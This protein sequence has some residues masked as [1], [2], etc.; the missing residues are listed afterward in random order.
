MI[1]NIFILLGIFIWVNPLSAQQEIMYTQF[2]FNKMT[3]NPAYA[4]L[5]GYHQF[6]L[7]YRDQ[8]N[9]FVG[10]PK[11]QNLSANLNTFFDG[12]VGVGIN[13]NRQS[14]GITDKIGL[15]GMYSYKFKIDEG[16]LS[17]GLETTFRRYRI[18]FTDDRLLAIEGLEND[19][20]I[21]NEARSKSILNV[22]LGFYY[23]TEQYFFGL[24]ATNLMR[25]K[26]DFDTNQDFSQEVL[27]LNAMLGKEF[28]ISNSLSLTPQLMLRYIADGPL[29]ADI[30]V[31]ASVYERYFGGIT[32]RT[33]GAQSDIGES[34]DI[35][36]GLHISDELMLGVAY[37]IGF[38]DLRKFHNGSFELTLNYN[39]MSKGNQVKM[40]NP[41]YF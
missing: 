2:M 39:L 29:S 38:S 18:D 21:P 23:H 5:D 30:N 31:M 12:S 11:A 24:S 32:Y 17:M 19:A 20:S 35:I 1:R 15:S 6:N 7:I 34:V 3:L 14:I 40:V 28:D 33:G 36:A 4:G 41:R 13:L 22:G 9:G 27:Q 37:D 26:L 10:S 8:W 25:A 16:V